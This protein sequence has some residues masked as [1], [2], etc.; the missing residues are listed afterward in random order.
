ML[1]EWLPRIGVVIGDDAHLDPRALFPAAPRQVWLEIG[2]GSGEHLAAQAAAH[3]DVGF[4]GCEPYVNGVAS[5][6]RH[7]ADAQ[8][9]NIRIYTDDARQLIDALPEASIDRLFLLFPDPWPKARHHKRRF[10]QSGNLD[11]LARILTDGAEFRFATDHMGYARWAL[12]H[13]TAHPAFAWPARGPADWRQPP[14][15]WKPTRYEAKSAARGL[16]R[17]YL[18]FRRK[19]RGA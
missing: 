2:F 1:E 3:P 5:L 17:A 6:L 16:A 7:V 13:V 11:A 15:D 19:P 18:G 9:S 4:V 14:A 12:A 8:L 10:I